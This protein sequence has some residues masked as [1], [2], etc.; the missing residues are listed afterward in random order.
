M[1][2]N[3]RQALERLIAIAKR[4]TGQCRRVANFLLTW[5]NVHKY[6]AW[7]TTD[8]WSLDDAIAEDIFIVLRLIKEQSIYPDDLGYEG[9]FQEIRRQWR[10]EFYIAETEEKE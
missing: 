6:G 7:C 1:K 10:P 8:L 5:W 9:D 3:Q 2:P 4:D